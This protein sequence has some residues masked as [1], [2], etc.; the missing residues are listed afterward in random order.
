MNKTTNNKEIARAMFLY[1][2]YS[3]LGPLL[4]IG[5]LGYILS[6]YFDN[7]FILFFSIF[8]AWLFSQVL[9]FKKLKRINASVEK[10]GE[11]GLKK[12]EENEDIKKK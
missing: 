7:R 11:E 6:R 5:G 3:I 4:L 8:I 1:I 9:M 10:I 2:S 12:E